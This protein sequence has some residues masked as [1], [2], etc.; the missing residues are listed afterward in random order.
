MRELVEVAELLNVH[1]PGVRAVW[2][3]G[4]EILGKPMKDVVF[5]AGEHG[6]EVELPKM[7]DTPER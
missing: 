5:E 4:E 3:G 2:A 7:K 6:K 1:D